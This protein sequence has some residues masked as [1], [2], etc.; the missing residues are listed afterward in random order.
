MTDEH[1]G[2]YGKYHV[3]RVDGKPIAGCFVLEYTDTRAWP[4]LLAYADSCG[5][6]VLAEDLRT[7]VRV[8]Q[9]HLPDHL[10]LMAVAPVPDQPQDGTNWPQPHAD[11]DVQ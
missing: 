8:W 3:E 5:D 10:Q 7:T 11:R 9:R 1:L 2:L 6:P 4:A